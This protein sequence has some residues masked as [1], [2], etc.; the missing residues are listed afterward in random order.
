MLNAHAEA[1]VNNRPI[2][3]TIKKGDTFYLLGKRFNSSVKVISSMNPKMDPH[4]LII[5]SKIKLPVGS[6]I[7]IHHVKK[8]DTL[9]NI[10]RNY[11][12][13][14]DMIAKKN[15]IVNPNIIYP[16]DF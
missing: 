5:G 7:K 14:V 4:N 2:H 1:K 13:T 3:Y 10:A 16:G 9:G 11:N 6:G 15:Y 12:S 8:G